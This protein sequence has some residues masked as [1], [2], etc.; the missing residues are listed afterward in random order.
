[1][2]ITE[3]LAE[4]GSLLPPSAS[5]GPNPSLPADRQWWSSIY[6][7]VWWH[8]ETLSWFQMYQKKKWVFRIIFPVKTKNDLQILFAREV[9]RTNLLQDTQKW[10]LGAGS[11]GGGA[12][13]VLRTTA[14]GLVRF[15][16]KTTGSVSGGAIHH[17]F[18]SY[19]FVTSVP[20][21]RWTIPAF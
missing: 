21:A 19:E 16:G 7:W 13:A 2:E 1:M 5:W 20:S 3:E 8:L 12:C 15:R 4:I 18:Y 17:G 10:R 14:T 6:W 9:F 11:V